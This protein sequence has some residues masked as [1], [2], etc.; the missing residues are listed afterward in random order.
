MLDEKQVQAKVEVTAGDVVI[1]L[2]IIQR[3]VGAGAI[4]DQEL[5]SVGLAR[6][7]L[8]A[9]LEK[10]T[11][12]NFDK[13]RAAAA[14]AAEEAKKRMQQQPQPVPANAPAAAV[15]PPVPVAPA[16]AAEVVPEAPP[17]EPAAP[18]A[19]EAAEAPAE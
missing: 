9:G 10:A 18:A 5:A 4:G 16:P 6:N 1:C 11:G 13:A 17:A 2:Q 12:V 7:S 19:E 3:L 8:I 15:P 14:R